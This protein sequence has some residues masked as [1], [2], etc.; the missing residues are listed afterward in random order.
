MPTPSTRCCGDPL[1]ILAAD[2]VRG[3]GLGLGHETRTTFM[4]AT[5]ILRHAAR[6]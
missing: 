5:T 6:G 2:D 4:F 3:L 1:E